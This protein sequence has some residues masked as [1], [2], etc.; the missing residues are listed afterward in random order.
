MNYL[1]FISSDSIRKDLSFSIIIPVSFVSVKQL[2]HSLNT[3]FELQMWV[4]YTHT[5]YFKYAL[6]LVKQAKF[7][8]SDVLQNLMVPWTKMVLVFVGVNWNE[9]D[10]QDDSFV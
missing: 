10:V 4:D 8:D 3:H 1:V 6:L 7:V 9:N 2:I 5:L